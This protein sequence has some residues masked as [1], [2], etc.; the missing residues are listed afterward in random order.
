MNL[1]YIMTPEEAAGAVRA[2]KPKV[3]YPYHSRNSDLAVF[4]KALAGAGVEVRI[5]NWY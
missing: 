5:R 3:V 1:P 4:Q 2:F